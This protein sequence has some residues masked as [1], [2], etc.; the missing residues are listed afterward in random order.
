MCR[1]CSAP[2]MDAVMKMYLLVLLMVTA[3]ITPNSKALADIIDPPPSY[4]AREQYMTKTPLHGDYATMHKHP[5]LSPA[6]IISQAPPMT[7]T[8]DSTMD[9][10]RSRGHELILPAPLAEGN[11]RE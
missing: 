5:T 4:E 10:P 9:A 2:R 8:Y 11:E 3:W 6:A 7:Y 1:L